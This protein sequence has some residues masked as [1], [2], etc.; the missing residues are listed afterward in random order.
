MIHRRGAEIAEK[1]EEKSPQMDTDE[2]RWGW[3]IRF[4]TKVRNKA[5]TINHS[6]HSTE[7][8]VEV[9]EK[10]LSGKTSRESLHGAKD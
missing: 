4:T 10:M 7:S 5:K 9:T 2:H 1:S 8:T 3:M 6:G